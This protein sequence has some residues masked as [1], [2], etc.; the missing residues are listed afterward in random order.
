MKT[1]LLAAILS[2][3]FVII[4]PLR[5]ETYPEHPD[6][7]VN[8]FANVLSVTDE[9]LIRE[10]LKIVYDQQ[11]VEVTVLTLRSMKDYGFNGEIEPYATRLFNA[12]GV[13]DATR[14]D[15]ILML[16]A[17]QDRQMRIELGAGYGVR[18]DAK[19]QGIIDRLMLPE[20]RKNRYDA[21][22]KAGVGGVIAFLGV[23]LAPAAP[24]RHS[25]RFWFTLVGIA[26]LV[27]FAV[28]RAGLAFY[29]RVNGPGSVRHMFSGDLA[30]VEKRCPV[31]Q[32]LM[33]LV[34]EEWEDK[35]LTPEQQSEQRVGS[36]DYLV[37]MCPTCPHVTI[38]AQEAWF[39]E[40]TA[41][42]KCGAKTLE[43]EETVTLQ[44][45]EQVPGIADV[46]YHCENCGA[47][48]NKQRTIP[49]RVISQLAL[50]AQE[51]DRSAASLNASPSG[52]SSFGSR[53]SSS[54]SSFGGGR[55]SGGGAS[56]RW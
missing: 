9:T 54:R 8:D 41:C 24:S 22:I 1:R 38:Q 40:Y 32:S 5:A 29:E 36:I 10:Q 6:L 51:M 2:A 56:G 4:G 55:S 49:P 21:G 37:W 42:G 47:R 45:T 52:F 19:M 48:Y 18:D 12:W 7:Y 23:D 44:P 34:V 11:L 17:V 30:P 33:N 3:L 46:E 31:D 16:V 20:F 28:I 14:N 50:Y 25:T 13:G 39:H 43:A 53:P 35:H 26:G 15:G 27:M